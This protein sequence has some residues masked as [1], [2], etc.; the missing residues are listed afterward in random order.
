MNKGH[1]FFAQNTEK[2]DYVTQAYVAALTIK[3]FNRNN[4]T[5]LITNDPVPVNYLKAFDHIV[6]I[7]WGDDASKSDWKIENRWKLIYSSPF[8]YTLVYDTDILLLSSNDYWWDYLTPHSLSFTTSVYDYRYNLIND[9]INRK[10][11]IHNY[12]PNVYFGTHYFKKDKKSYEFYKWLEIITKNYSK[13][14]QEHTPYYTQKFASMDVSSAV[15]CKLLDINIK[16][17]PLQFIHMKT[18]L[19]SWETM[20]NHWYEA[21]ILEFTDDLELRVSNFLQNGVFHYV[22][23]TFLTSNIIN[24]VEKKYADMVHL[25]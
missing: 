19:Q 14:Y 24:K 8:D 25:L 5:C 13:F 21:C 10:S 16:N 12:L 11:F 17:S 3:I 18:E 6:P 9:T 1:L 2:I 7:P 22:D 23:E 4:H 20:P 15:I